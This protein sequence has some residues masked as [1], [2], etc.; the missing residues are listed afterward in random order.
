VI[1]KYRARV[2][3]LRAELAAAGGGHDDDYDQQQQPAASSETPGKHWCGPSPLLPLHR[4][5]RCHCCRLAAA[6]PVDALHGWSQQFG[7]CVFKV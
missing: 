3:A 4:C 5:D 1:A 2:A 6:H 7:P